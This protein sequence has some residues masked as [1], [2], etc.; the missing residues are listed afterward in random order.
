LLGADVMVDENGRPWLLEINNCPNIRCACVRAC[1]SVYVSE[2]VCVC[3][4]KHIN[5]PC[6]S[7]ETGHVAR[8]MRAAA[9]RGDAF[10]NK[11]SKN[12]EVLAAA[13]VDGRCGET[14][15]KCDS[16]CAGEGCG[17]E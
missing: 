6:N 13:L 12:Y 16:I 11:A 1:V 4:C 8:D 2:S 5:C 10:D 17:A 15:K 9:W 3:V 7:G 14:V